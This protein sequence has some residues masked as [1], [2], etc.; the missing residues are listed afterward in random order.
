M[1]VIEIIPQIR[2]RETVTVMDPI[3]DLRWIIDTNLGMDAARLFDDIIYD[4]KSGPE[5]DDYEQ[6]ADGY[7]RMLVDT[8]NELHE[9]ISQ[10]RLNRK[11]LEDLYKELDSNL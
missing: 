7:R 2:K 6:I 3:Q 5:G 9:I 11:R 10:N 4:L 8:M 1:N